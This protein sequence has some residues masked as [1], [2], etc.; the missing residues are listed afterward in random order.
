VVGHW[1][2]DKM[3]QRF[4]S[5]LGIFWMLTLVGWLMIVI[6]AQPSWADAVTVTDDWGQSISLA[7]PAQRVIP[8]YGAFT[9]VLFAI[10]AGPQVV[11]RTEADQEPPEI[12]Q[13]PAVG[14]HMRPNLEMI[15]ALKPQLVVQSASRRAASPEIQRVIEAG[16]PV[17][18]FAPNT[19]AEIFQ[20]IER[21]GALTGRE[22]AARDLARKMRE[23]LDVVKQ[24]LA[25]E[26]KR[27]R[28]FFEVRAEP[29]TA[30]G[31][32]SLVE[33]ILNAVQAENVVTVDK[34]IVSTDLEAL[35][36]QNPDVYVVQRG[37][38]NRNPI[39]P[40]QRQHFDRIQAIQQGQVFFVDEQLY[41]RP[42]PRCVDAVEELAAA[43]YP[44]RFPDG[45]H[46]EPSSQQ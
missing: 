45:R 40:R 26:P 39:D 46:R 23:R 34:A 38:M 21:L 29:L 32:E 36:L 24:R 43:L 33:E 14:T 37:P 41:S 18:V 3:T 27:P 31:R 4:R 16:I 13:L 20:T 11:A 30:A 8:L 19:F 35:L 42:G 15:I 2:K 25:G 5:W 44:Q 9:E 12:L 6:A 1:D 10:G 7:E 22:Q 28:V 17:A